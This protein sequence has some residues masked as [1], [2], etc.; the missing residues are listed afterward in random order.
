[1]SYRVAGGLETP[2]GVHHIPPHG[3]AGHGVVVR[4][5]VSHTQGSRTSVDL[6]ANIGN[7]VGAGENGPAQCLEKETL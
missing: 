2:L 1:M 7:W 6:E 3:L 5:I 4:L